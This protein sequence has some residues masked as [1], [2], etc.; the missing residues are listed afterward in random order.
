LN[1]AGAAR[2]AAEIGGNLNPY[3][4][5]GHDSALCEM[6]EAEDDRNGPPT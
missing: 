4:K 6:F 1:P 5:Q 2:S 3:N